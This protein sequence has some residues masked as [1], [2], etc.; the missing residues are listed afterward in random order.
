VWRSAYRRGDH[1]NKFSALELIASQCGEVFLM[2]RTDSNTS[3][4]GNEPGEE[5]LA[6]ERAA[7]Q[8]WKICLII[9]AR[10][11][12]KIVLVLSFSYSYY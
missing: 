3:G 2:S 6:Q 5:N 10:M 8:L 9:F 1:L 12:A 4:S 7:E 11:L